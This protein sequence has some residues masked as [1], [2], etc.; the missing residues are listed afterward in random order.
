MDYSLLRHWASVRVGEAAKTWPP[1]FG[2]RSGVGEQ[3][4]CV[5]SNNLSIKPLLHSGS[6]TELIWIAGYIVGK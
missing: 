4:G 1:Q 6:I 3:G 2:R 5:I